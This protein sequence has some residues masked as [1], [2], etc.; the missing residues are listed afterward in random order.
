MEMAAA[1]GGEAGVLD[2]AA[3]AF[4]ACPPTH[5][6]RIKTM[7]HIKRMFHHQGVNQRFDSLYCTNE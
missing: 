3:G 4:A 1:C 6:T 2:E 5:G 7:Q